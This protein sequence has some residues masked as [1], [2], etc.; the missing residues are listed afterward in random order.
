MGVRVLTTWDSVKR[1]KLRDK[2]ILSYHLLF[3]FQLI[4]VSPLKMAEN[5]KNPSFSFSLLHFLISLLWSKLYMQ[6][7]CLSSQILFLIL[8]I[9]WILDSLSDLLASAVDAAKR[10]GEVC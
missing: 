1:E 9:I 6:F 10:A 7:S 2:H 5:G 8:Q 4:S 3:K